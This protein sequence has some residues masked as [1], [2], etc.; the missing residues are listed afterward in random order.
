MS[1]R[2][3]SGKTQNLKIEFEWGTCVAASIVQQDESEV[4]AA[5]DWPKGIL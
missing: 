3:K 2:G 4:Q 5:S 1:E